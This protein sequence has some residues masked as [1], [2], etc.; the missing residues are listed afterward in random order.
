MD[1]QQ[2]NEIKQF[3][4]TV[5]GRYTKAKKVLDNIEG[6]ELRYQKASD[7]T[8]KIVTETEE[9]RTEVQSLQS[10]AK[11]AL[12]QIQETRTGISGYLEAAKTTIEK[13]QELSNSAAT[14]KGQIDGGKGEIDA[15]LQNSRN[16]TENIT[17]LQ[18]GAEDNLN[19][20]EKLLADFQQKVELMKTAFVE[21]TEI[22]KKIDD[23]NTGL[24][25]ALKLVQ[26]AQTDSETLLTEIKQALQQSQASEKQI[27]DIKQRSSDV[28][29]DIKTSL[30]EVNEKKSQ[31]EEAAA[32]TIDA[33]FAGKFESRKLEIERGLNKDIFSWKYILFFSVLLLV[34][35]VFLPFLPKVNQ[36]FYLGEL[37]GV[38][39]FLIRLFYT[40]PLVFL[41]AFSATQYSRERALLERYAFKAAS[42]AAIRNHTD[43]L[44]QHFTPKEVSAF[45]LKVFASIYGEPFAPVHEKEAK[46]IKIQKKDAGI[47]PTNDNDLFDNLKTLIPDEELLSK[48]VD[49]LI[50]RV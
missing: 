32:I 4:D 24:D 6:L 42:A 23:K 50:K 22:K 15:L 29:E 45:T 39:G 48:V 19:E 11:V 47:K 26:Q 37:V 9:G 3:L 2:I 35:A 38:N 34:L 30:Q 7:A 5:K 10:Q 31:V 49:L 21:F 12:E 27:A 44:L 14:L 17:K 40:S 33:S 8:D 28:F 36:F 18:K 1:E 13:L 46:K 25:A 20:S 43:F 16:L 41:V